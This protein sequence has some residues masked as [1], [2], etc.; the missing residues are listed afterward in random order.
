MARS[1]PGFRLSFPK[2]W[3]R[4]IDTHR[5]RA[6]QCRAV[7]VLSFFDPNGFH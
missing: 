7:T 6:L 4:L 5:F 1:A 3:S 2:P